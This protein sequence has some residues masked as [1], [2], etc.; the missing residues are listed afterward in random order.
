MSSDA[1]GLGV[2]G[3]EGDSSVVF[4]SNLLHVRVES[5]SGLALEVKKLNQSDLSV[6]RRVQNVT[7]LSHHLGLRACGGALVHGRGDTDGDDGDQGGDEHKHPTPDG[8]LC[9]P[10]ITRSR[11]GVGGD[12]FGF[13]VMGS[14]CLVSAADERVRIDGCRSDVD[15]K[16]R[17]SARGGPCIADGSDLLASYNNLT[18]LDSG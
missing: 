2:A 11:G 14:S 18:L 15:L 7:V 16:M 6:L 9:S 10:R 4:L 12:F 3:H 17:V 5:T 8:N 1:T 13:C